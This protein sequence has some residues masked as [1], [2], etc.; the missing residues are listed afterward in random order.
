MLEIGYSN[1]IQKTLFN[2]LNIYTQGG[3]LFPVDSIRE[4]ES[5]RRGLNNEWLTDRPWSTDGVV[6]HIRRLPF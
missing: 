5:N 3:A 4:I 1:G 6:V 2:P